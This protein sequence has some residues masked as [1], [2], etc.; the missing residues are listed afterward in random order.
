MK[1]PKLLFKYTLKSKS[2][3][4]LNPMIST[5]AFSVYLI[6]VYITYFLP[7]NVIVFNLFNYI[8]ISLYL[9]FC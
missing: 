5:F 2:A 9:S 4:A 7:I 1:N 6:Y 3:S 8:I